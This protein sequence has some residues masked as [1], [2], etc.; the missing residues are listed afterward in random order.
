VG[1][2]PRYKKEI[3]QYAP[4]VITPTLIQNLSTEEDLN[5][6]KKKREAVKKVVDFT[7]FNIQTTK[8]MSFIYAIEKVCR[9]YAVK[10]HGVK[11]TRDYD[12]SF[13]INSGDN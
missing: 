4:N 11:G 7:Q 13:D 3:P 9:K 12:F 1:F 8:P 6:A 2:L 10:L 5:M